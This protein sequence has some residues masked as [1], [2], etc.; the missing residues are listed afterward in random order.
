MIVINAI[1]IVH[2]KVMY[3]HIT[4]VL[5]NVTHTDIIGILKSEGDAQDIC[6]V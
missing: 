3:F 5:L 1:A 6:N 4:K 2:L